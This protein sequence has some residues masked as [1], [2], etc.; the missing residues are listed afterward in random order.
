MPH[1][2]KNIIVSYKGEGVN[3]HYWADGNGRKVDEYLTS[4]RQLQS[5]LNKYYHVPSLDLYTLV[6]RRMVHIKS[7]SR[8]KQAL[9][10]APSGGYL[11][12]YAFGPHELRRTRKVPEQSPFPL[13]RQV[14]QKPALRKK[15]RGNNAA[16]VAVQ[17]R[18]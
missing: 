11:F 12:V 8:L 7:D 17:K 16:E 5:R 3:V 6:D 13:V 15:R 9:A 4:F 10:T 2:T 18:L 14:E 1:Q